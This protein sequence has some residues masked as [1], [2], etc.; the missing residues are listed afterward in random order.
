MSDFGAILLQRLDKAENRNQ[1]ISNHS[2]TALE[3]LDKV[4]PVLSKRFK[5]DEAIMAVIRE[6][7]SVLEEGAEESQSTITEIKQARDSLDIALN[8]LKQAGYDIANIQTFSKDEIW[9]GDHLPTIKRALE[10]FNTK[11]AEQGEESLF[12]QALDSLENERFV[13]IAHAVK[14][15]GEKRQ[16]KAEAAAASAGPETNPETEAAEA[17]LDAIDAIKKATGLRDALE[18]GQA[19]E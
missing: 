17:A 1:Q 13:E 3:R 12:D 8:L 15:S 9:L 19:Q 16:S 18:D 7:Y 11:P 14:R 5:G 10:V 4:L 6:V 2:H